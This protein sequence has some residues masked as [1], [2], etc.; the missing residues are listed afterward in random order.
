MRGHCQAVWCGLTICELKSAVQLYKSAD[1]CVD[2]S[3][4]FKLVYKMGHIRSH[5]WK[6]YQGKGSD[7]MWLYK[8]A[9]LNINFTVSFDPMDR[10]Q[11]VG[12]HFGVV[13]QGQA[14]GEVT[15]HI[16]WH[17]R[18]HLHNLQYSGQISTCKRFNSFQVVAVML[19]YSLER[20]QFIEISLEVCSSCF[21]TGSRYISLKWN[22]SN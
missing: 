1:I 15:V 2:F 16:S 13:L 11:H 21:Q 10:F 18:R 17:G 14:N 5:F 12:G 6:V 9:D 4:P 19:R 20:Y 8:T 3:L 22:S 7:Q